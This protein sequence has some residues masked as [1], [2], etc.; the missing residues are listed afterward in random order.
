MLFNFLASSGLEIQFLLHFGAILVSNKMFSF[1]LGF[2]V[3]FGN[4]RLI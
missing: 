1:L 4:L 3:K 2:V